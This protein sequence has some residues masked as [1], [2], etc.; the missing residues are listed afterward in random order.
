MAY[1]QSGHYAKLADKPS[2]DYLEDTF[3]IPDDEHIT[4]SQTN[5]CFDGAFKTMGVQRG[6]GAGQCTLHIR[7]LSLAH[8]HSPVGLTLNSSRLPRGICSL[9]TSSVRKYNEQQGNHRRLQ[10]YLFQ[11]HR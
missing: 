11:F 7:T 8:F 1:P 10:H 2:Q 6:R 5:A 9:R 3:V 4:V